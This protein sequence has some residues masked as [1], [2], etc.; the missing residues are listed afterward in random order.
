MSRL[1]KSFWEKC[2]DWY[3]WNRVKLNHLWI[4]KWTNKLLDTMVDYQ[5]HQISKKKK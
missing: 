3:F 2:K 1:G 4:V 5:M